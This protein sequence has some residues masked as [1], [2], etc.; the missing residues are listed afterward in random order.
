MKIFT[1][2]LTRAIWVGQ[3]FILVSFLVLFASVS[4][5]GTPS[6]TLNKNSQKYLSFYETIDGET[7]H[8]EVNFEGN[9]IASIYKNGKKIPDELKSDYRD[10]INNQLDEMRFGERNFTFRMPFPPADRWEF[11]MEDLE[12]NLDELRKKFK[13]HKWN[14]EE[15]NFDDEK[16][17]QEMKELEEKLKK[18]NFHQF[19]WKFDDEKFWEQMEK[20]EEN[21]RKH[22]DKFEFHLDWDETNDDEV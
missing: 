21:L 4:C 16:L 9:E 18:Q 22:L 7:V 6:D 10:K 8:W 5:A 20:L 15:F 14:F 17:K 3:L 1:L 11:Y 19:R 13:D 12:K 2:H